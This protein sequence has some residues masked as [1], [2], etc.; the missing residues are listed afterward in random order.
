MK[1]TNDT[2]EFLTI[3]GQALDSVSRSSRIV[4]IASNNPAVQHGF[5]DIEYIKIVLR[6]L[7]HSVNGHVVFF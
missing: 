2:Y 7:F 6:H 1:S 4:F 3:Q 5:F